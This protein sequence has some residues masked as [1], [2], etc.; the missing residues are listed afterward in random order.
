MAVLHVTKNDFQEEVLN[1]KGVVLV[2]F[3]ASWCGPCKMLSPIIEEL[4]NEMTDV[5]FVKIDVDEQNELASKYGVMSIPTMLVFKDGH[6][7]NNAV[8]F[9]SKEDIQKMVL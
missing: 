6:I 3:F 5:K 8:G 9:R 7:I 4:A 1:A 2:D